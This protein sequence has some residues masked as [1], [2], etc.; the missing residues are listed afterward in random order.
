MLGYLDSYTTNKKYYSWEEI[1][2]HNGEG[3][4]VMKGVSWG[5]GEPT[6]GL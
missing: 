6:M 4:R 2:C 1:N 3:I 5:A